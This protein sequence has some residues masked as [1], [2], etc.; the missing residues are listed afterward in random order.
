MNKSFIQKN[1][2]SIL[3]DSDTSVITLSITKSDRKKFHYYFFKIEDSLKNNKH[4]P[5]SFELLTKE[6]GV[7]ANRHYNIVAV[8][9]DGYVVFSLNK[10]HKV[11][12][13]YNSIGMVGLPFDEAEEIIM[14]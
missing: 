14:F 4:I 7:G 9:N 1:A 12:F 5:I 11:E 2:E 3:N 8:Y 10:N 13:N 6:N